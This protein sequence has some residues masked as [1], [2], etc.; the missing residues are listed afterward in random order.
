MIRIVSPL[1]V[2]TA[3]VLSGLP[4]PAAPPRPNILLAIA[5]DWSFGHAG[6]YGCPWVETPAFDRVARSG[7]LFHQA[8]TPNA[9]C[10]PSRAILLTG[11]HSWQ[12]EQAANHLCLFPPQ[13][14]TWMEVL[15]E[16]GYA[17]GFT[18]KGWGPGIAV[19]SRGHP[20][21]MTGTRFSPRRTER[22]L[23][24][25]S[26]IDYTAGFEAFLE[27]VPE[28]QPWCFWYGAFEPHRPYEAGS[29]RRSGKTVADIDRVPAFWPDDHI[30]R[31]DMLDYAAEVEYFDAHLGRILDVIERAGLTDSTLVIVTSDHGMP[32]PRCKGQAY[33][34]SCHVPLA[35]M[36][37]D[38]IRG[39]GR[40]VDDYVSFTDI[41]PT[42][43]E[44][45]GLEWQATGMA[46]AAGH[47]LQEMF[48][49]SRSGRIVSWRD[50][51]LLG[52]ERHDA[53]RPHNGGYPIRGILSSDW[54]YLRN[55]HPD[56]WPAGN[57]ETGYLNCDGGPTKSR[58][59]SLRRAHP[60][61]APHWDLCFGRRP[62]EELYHLASDPDC[63]I[64][65]AGS[66]DHQ[67]RLRQLRQ[68]METELRDQ[69]DPRMA[70]R[71]EV[72]D[73]YPWSRPDL[74]DFYERYRA[75]Q[76]VRAGWVLPTDFEPAPLFEAA[77]QEDGPPQA[78]P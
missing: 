16:H 28:G 47:S 44:A 35:M 31:S 30:V 46:P 69:K 48:I 40:Q 32:F 17:T 20:R 21:Q 73:Q 64:N 26:P 71:G 70:G 66:T 49:S 56:R 76:P 77:A 50:H 1:V 41:A 19:D 72:F 59:L 57:P 74:K 65:L 33:D 22:P 58:I 13:F 43:I 55:W 11:R 52:K 9:K 27:S 37:P 62:A 25:V 14:R 75:G 67:E 63:V 8:Y 54:L 29:G 38:G 53:G 10:A 45:A 34:A 4:A 61:S 7:I 15:N 23:S 51:V 3:S 18:G 60:E 39:R 6:A 24:G 36:W 2:L 42:L 68:Q 78:A 12:L 5:D